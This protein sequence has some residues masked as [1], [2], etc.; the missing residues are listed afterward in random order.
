MPRVDYFSEYGYLVGSSTAT[1]VSGDG[2]QLQ[3]PVPDLSYAWSGSY[4]IVVTN[5]ES[6]GFYA[7]RVGIAN[8]SCW[9]RDRPDS[10][11]DGFYDDEDCYPWDYSRW[12]CYEPG[13]CGEQYPNQNPHM[14]QWPCYE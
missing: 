4:Q 11:G 7:V 9:G 8:V 10:D 13:G 1:Y 5:M 3:A 14:E 12:N 6:N 2:T